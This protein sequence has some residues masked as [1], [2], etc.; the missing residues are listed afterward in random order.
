MLATATSLPELSTAV[1]AVRLN[2]HSMAISN[3]FGSNL[4]MLLLLF[5]SDVFYREGLIID[6]IDPSARFAL[7]VGIV[8]TS[9][10]VIG[11]FMR[12]PRRFLGL[13]LDSW[14]VLAAYIA[15]L[16]FLYHVR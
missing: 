1:T 11:L 5:P 2:N 8:L 6:A 14:A 16:F 7:V 13:G 10:Y 4:V 3:V 9:I 15:A 12:S